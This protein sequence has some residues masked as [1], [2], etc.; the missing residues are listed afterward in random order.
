MPTGR[1]IVE[2]YLVPAA[3][4]TQLEST[5]I[6]GAEVI[7]VAKN[8]LSKSSSTNRDDA[9]YTVHFQTPD[10]QYRNV[11]SNAVIDASGT[12]YSP[13]PIGLDC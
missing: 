3:T 9:G 11:E 13:N 6:Y 8:N 1:E 5:I 4:T 12:L 7:A 2:Q 10:G